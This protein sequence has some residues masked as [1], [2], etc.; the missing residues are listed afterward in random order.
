[1]LLFGWFWVLLFIILWF[2]INEI[3]FFEV[4]GVFVCDLFLR[5]LEI[6]GFV[7]FCIV[8]IFM[9]FLG[10]EIEGIIVKILFFGYD[11]DD[12]F[13]F[14]WVVFFIINFIRRRWFEY[15][16][17]VIFWIRR[18]SYVFFCFFWKNIDIFCFFYSID[19]I[20]VD[21]FFYLSCNFV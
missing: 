4:L 8:D 21:S 7:L 2:E 9:L 5:I 3:C 1:M 20:F 15:F 11:I 19:F 17:K 10:Y 13:F 6:V 16:F 18:F 14:Y 12:I